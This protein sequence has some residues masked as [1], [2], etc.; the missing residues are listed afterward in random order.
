MLETDQVRVLLVALEKIPKIR[1][2]VEGSGSSFSVKM[3][4]SISYL[5]SE[6]A[7][8]IV[9]ELNEMI[10]PTLDRIEARTRKSLIT[11]AKTKNN[12]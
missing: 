5:T 8:R 1:F 10:Q 7:Q 11:I 4:D 9:D 3:S 6:E 12:E 2:K